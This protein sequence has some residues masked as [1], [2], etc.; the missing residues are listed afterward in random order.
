MSLHYTH[1]KTSHT[2][3]QI[4]KY[5]LPQRLFEKNIP[6]LHTEKVRQSAI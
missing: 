6:I 2:S 1:K 4:A 3:Q 5:T